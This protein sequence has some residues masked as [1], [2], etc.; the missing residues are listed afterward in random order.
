MSP[1]LG[2]VLPAGIRRRQC[3]SWSGAETPQKTE[4]IYYVNDLGAAPPEWR[5]RDMQSMA[6]VSSA[7]AGSITLG[8]AVGPTSVHRRPTFGQGRRHPRNARTC[9]AVPG[10]ADRIC[11][12]SARALESVASTTFC[13]CT[14]T[15]S[16][17]INEPLKFTTRYDSDLSRG[18]SLVSR[19]TA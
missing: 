10:P 17:K 18:S 9:S 11:L 1:N 4:V 19:R 15:R 8:V 13:G 14:A 3:Q 2:A 7:T 5:I 6:K 16:C 12:S